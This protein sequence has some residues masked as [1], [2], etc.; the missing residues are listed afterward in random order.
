MCP[1]SPDGTLACSHP[2][3]GLRTRGVSWGKCLP[4]S[5]RRR[6]WRPGLSRLHQSTHPTP[7]A[8]L[9]GCHLCHLRCSPSPRRSGVRLKVPGGRFQASPS[10]W[11]SRPFTSASRCSTVFSTIWSKRDENRVGWGRGAED[12]SGAQSCLVRSFCVQRGE[13]WLP[14]PFL[15]SLCLAHLQVP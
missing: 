4:T 11:L 5:V 10:S 9:Q 2:G 7:L 12:T 13:K 15:F 3:W 8:Q 6:S 1:R 14:R